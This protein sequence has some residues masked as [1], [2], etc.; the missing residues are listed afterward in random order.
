M[1]SMSSG[2]TRNGGQDLRVLQGSRICSRAPKT[3]N[4]KT[5]NLHS[6][7]R[8]Q[9]KVDSR[10]LVCRILMLKKDP[11]VYIPCTIYHILY[12][13]YY[14]PCQDPCVY[15]ACWAPTFRLASYGH[16]EL[17]GTPWLQLKSSLSLPSPIAVGT[18]RITKI[19]VPCS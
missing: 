11:C 5:R 15:L 9:D 14:I 19:T 3:I 1:G 8:A 17:L 16:L 12:T 2:R 13:I 6:G 18:S 7:S 10:T 4:K